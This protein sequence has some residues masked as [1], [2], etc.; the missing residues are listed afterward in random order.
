MKDNEYEGYFSK[1]RTGIT[2]N[3]QKMRAVDV[4]KAIGPT[5]SASAKIS[6]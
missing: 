5:V 1:R 6:H 4:E 3:E 2:G